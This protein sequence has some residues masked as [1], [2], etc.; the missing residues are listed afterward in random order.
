[1]FSILVRGLQEKRSKQVLV[2]ESSDCCQYLHNMLLVHFAENNNLDNNFI[3]MFS[4]SH[5]PPHCSVVVTLVITLLLSA[6]AQIVDF[7][8]HWRSGESEEKK[9]H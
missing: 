6:S 2:S 3:N 5:L 8:G 4:K 9:Y 1:M 7:A